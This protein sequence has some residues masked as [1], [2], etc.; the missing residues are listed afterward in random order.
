MWH[1]VVRTRKTLHWVLLTRFF[2]VG[3]HELSLNIFFLFNFQKD[4]W[5]N[6]WFSAR[7]VYSDVSY[8]QKEEPVEMIWILKDSTNKNL[9]VASINYCIVFKWINQSNNVCVMC[10]FFPQPC[11]GKFSLSLVVKYV[12]GVCGKHLTVNVSH[13]PWTRLC[14]AH[15]SS[16]EFTNS[17]EIFFFYTCIFDEPCAL[18]LNTDQRRGAGIWP[19][20][21]LHTKALCLWPGEGLHPT[22]THL[23]Q[24]GSD[25]V[26]PPVFRCNFTVIHVWCVLC[27]HRIL[28]ECSFLFSSCQSSTPSSPPAP[29][30]PTPPALAG[31]ACRFCYC[32]SHHSRPPCSNTAKQARPTVQSGVML[33]RSRCCEVYICP[34]WI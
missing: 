22:W 28:R 2:N 14:Q 34:P 8:W 12:A 1:A 11:F 10:N 18:L 31:S 21:L 5:A 16:A 20:P 32:G 13:S 9:N 26:C 19:R 3:R 15:S 7:G 25:C 23:G 17:R 24:V 30:N 6:V 33:P 4:G 27:L 29:P